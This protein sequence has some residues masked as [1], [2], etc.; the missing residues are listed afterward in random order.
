MYDK[1]GTYTHSEPKFNE[2]KESEVKKFCRDRE[3]I[4]RGQEIMILNENQKTTSCVRYLIWVYYGV[5]L[6]VE[7]EYM[8]FFFLK[9][10]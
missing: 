5:K 7:F 3:M 4:V 9:I 2:Q 8:F 6:T 1:R 10:F